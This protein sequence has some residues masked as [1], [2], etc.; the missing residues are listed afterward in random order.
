MLKHRRGA[1]HL[2]AGVAS[3]EAKRAVHA[4]RY[5]AWALFAVAAL[6]IPAFYLELAGPAHPYWQIGRA[7]YVTIFVAF[8]AAALWYA[9]VLNDRRRH[10]AANLLDVA[11]L[12][13]AASSVVGY[14]GAWDTAEW[15]FHMLLVGV[16]ALRLALPLVALFNP[17]RLML[18][19]VAGGVSIALAGEGFYLLE[20]RVH[21]YAE[22]VWL[23]FES[24]ATVGYGDIS[25]S[26]PASRVFAM[27]VILIGYGMLSLV[28]ATIAAKFIGRE[29]QRLRQ[30]MHRDIQ[31]LCAEVAQLRS[32]LESS[33]LDASSGT[34]PP[35]KPDAPR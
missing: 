25:P 31:R 16:V 29:E 14:S 35:S 15:L 21:S 18:L 13:G 6:W 1:L 4:Q 23:A 5:I 32:A 11:I 7:L 33:G 30:E 8:A 9:C 26:T 17:D 10:F 3:H 24:G 2:L 28:F 12:A 27:F 34:A 20:P 22:G 19:L